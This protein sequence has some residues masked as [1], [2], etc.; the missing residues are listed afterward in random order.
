MHAVISGLES[1]KK[2]L[3]KDSN[4]YKIGRYFQGDLLT[5]T[6][7]IFVRTFPFFL[8]RQNKNRIKSEVFY[9]PKIKKII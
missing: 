4:N 2:Y 9:K 6:L 7:F 5:F 8:K 3:I 1:M